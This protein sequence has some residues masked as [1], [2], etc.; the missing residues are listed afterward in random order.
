MLILP[1]Y[2][3]Y[4][5]TLCIL[6]KYAVCTL[7]VFVL[8]FRTLL[9]RYICT[10]PHSTEFCVTAKTQLHLFPKFSVTLYDDSDVFFLS[11]TTNY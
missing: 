1:F 10:L 9:R 7:E 8:L 3:F 2:A 5:R 6:S 11:P 4:A